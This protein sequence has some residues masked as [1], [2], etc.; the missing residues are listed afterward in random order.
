MS[1]HYDGNQFTPP[2]NLTFLVFKDS[3]VELLSALGVINDQAWACCKLIIV[4]SVRHSG[5]NSQHFS[6]SLLFRVLRIQQLQQVKA[7]LNCDEYLT[8][9]NY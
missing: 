6:I 9:I 2:V 7:A 8:P 3:S 5:R 1:T 4:N